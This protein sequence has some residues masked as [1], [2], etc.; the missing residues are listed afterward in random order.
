MEEKELK[1][2]SIEKDLDTRGL[3]CPDPLFEIEGVSEKLKIGQCFRVVSDD[4]DS[5]QEFQKWSHES[6]T[7]VI[8]FEED[9]QDF[10]FYFQKE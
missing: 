6:Q 7:K 10:I 1:D 8:G 3:F 4:P 9:G 5:K 2:I